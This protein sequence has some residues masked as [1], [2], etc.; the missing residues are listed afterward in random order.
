MV[1]VLFAP[2]H[3][4]LAG[5]LGLITLIS[6]YA[7]Y[8]CVAAPAGPPLHLLPNKEK[9]FLAIE[10]TKS[11]PR[12][13]EKQQQKK[14]LTA[15][16]LRGHPS[17]VIAANF[18][19]NHSC[20]AMGPRPLLGGGSKNYFLCKR[21]TSGVKHPWRTKTQLS[22]YADQNCV[23][24]LCLLQ[25]PK[26]CPLPLQSVSC[27]EGLSKF[28]YAMNAHESFLPLELID[29]P[30]PTQQL[31][32]VVRPLCKSGSIRDCLH[33]CSDDIFV[34]P[35]EKWDADKTQVLHETDIRTYSRQVLGALAELRAHGI[36]SNRLSASNVLVY[37]GQA[38]LTG[39]ERILLCLPLAEDV[40][41]FLSHM[42]PSLP[43]DVALFGRFVYEMATGDVLADDNIDF[44]GVPAPSEFLYDLLRYIFWWRLGEPSW[45]LGAD[46]DADAET[47]AARVELTPQR[48]L[49]HPFFAEDSNGR[50]DRDRDRD[51]D[52]GDG[53]YEP[54]LDFDGDSDVRAILSQCA[55]AAR[56]HR[57]KRRRKMRRSERPLRPLRPARGTSRGARRS[58]KLSKVTRFTR[59]DARSRQ[60][61]GDSLV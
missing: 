8:G 61:A 10:D 16:Q 18:C 53:D 17:H 23:P 50:N 37:N 5:G 19:K 56:S 12:Q 1:F 7:I 46:A 58:K 55:A 22:S 29:Y 48:L 11:P 30:L 43:S 54:I 21:N 40:R 33:K 26:R 47:S 25:K 57:V 49:T 60:I 51:A 32:A 14:V 36:T 13:N 41:K 20:Y 3:M 27:R 39:I 59:R 44:V 42:P 52:C 9:H 15:N 34:D 35:R 31:L 6:G 24:L 2:L 45:Q 28:L 38:T 4:A